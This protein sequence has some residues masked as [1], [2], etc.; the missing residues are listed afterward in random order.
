MGTVQWDD[1]L[2]VGVDLIDEQHKALIQRLN[3]MSAAV[4]AHEGEREI[5]RTLSFLIDYTD[6]HFSTE[7]KHMEAQGYPGADAHLEKHK[8][9]T[10]TLA[11]MEQDF[12]EEGST[13]ALADALN[14]FLGNWLLHHIRTVDHQFARFLEEKGVTLPHGD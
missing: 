13:K 6:F 14:T 4:E 12:R 9:F 7:K 10:D 1:R 3:D 8:E 5:S 2:S 11:D